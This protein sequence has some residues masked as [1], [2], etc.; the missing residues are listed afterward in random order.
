MPKIYDNSH[1]LLNDDI[2][3][4]KF[5]KFITLNNKKC[6]YLFEKYFDI[7]IT[8][9]RIVLKSYNHYF[10]NFKMKILEIIFFIVAL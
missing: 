9:Y 2:Y 5:L 1:L 10:T 8:R 3:Q 7:K 4:N 6:I